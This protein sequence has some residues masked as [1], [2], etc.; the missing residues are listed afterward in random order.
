[1]FDIFPLS[2]VRQPPRNRVIALRDSLAPG[3]WYL[4]V[5][6]D[7]NRFGEL[8]MAE[9]YR[10]LKEALY[11]TDKRLNELTWEMKKTNKWLAGLQF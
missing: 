11:R 2:L 10:S 4:R 5:N 3:P 1:M 7:V 8:T 9:I 6:L